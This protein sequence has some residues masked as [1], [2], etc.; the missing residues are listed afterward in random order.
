M[1]KI[2]VKDINGNNV[3]VELI[4]TANVKNKRYLLYRNDDGDIFASYIYTDRDDEKLYN[5]LTDDEYTMLD[6]LLIKGKKLYDK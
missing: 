1:D 2:I 5:D 4:L 3:E 6:N